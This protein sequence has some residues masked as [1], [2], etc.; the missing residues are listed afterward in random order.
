MTEPL[1][2]KP[3]LGRYGVW[4]LGPVQPE[5]AVEIEGLGYGGLWVG[6]SPAADLAFAEPILERTQTLQLATGIVNIW[7]A[8][9]NAIAESFHR[10]E[11]AHPGRFLLGIGVGHPE[12]TGEYRKPYDALV[13]YLDVLDA[14]KVP[15]SRLVIAALGD[16][17]LKL[18][19]LRSA[20]AHPY[21]T[22]PEHT[23]H[24]RDVLG[25]AVF[26]APE[27]KVV[28]STDGA[29]AR[30][31]GRDTV[32]FYLNLSNYLNNWRRLG[33]TED[34]IAKPGSDK[35]IDAVVAHGTADAISARLQQHIANGADHVAIQVLGG[36]DKLIPTLTDLAGPLGLK[37]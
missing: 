31:M 5:Q 26:L 23:A 14:A 9:A 7:T 21:L 20:G 36:P 15:T 24:A 27:H 2:L 8:D 4:T 35:L 37:D 11:A 22:T 6:G 16:K 10:I 29:A 30:A 28:L 1:A 12:H 19:A 34:D 32:D 17:V 33:F 13:E 3:D 18:S 25:E